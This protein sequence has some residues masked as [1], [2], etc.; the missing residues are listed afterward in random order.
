MTDRLSPILVKELRQGMRARMFESS[1]V[2]VQV[3]VVLSMI[4]ALTAAA[5]Q[6]MDLSRAFGDG[7]FWIVLA[8]SLL[9]IMPLRGATAL[10]SEARLGALDLLFLTRLSAWR[11]VVGKWAALFAQSCLV[12]CAVLPYG[13]LRYYLG[14]VDLVRDSMV[15]L[16][17]MLASALFTALTVS[18]SAFPS[19]L[20]RILVV[21]VPLMVLNLLPVGLMA[22]RAGPMGG[23]GMIG[24]RSDWHEVL[25]T[26]GYALIILAYILQMGAAR[27]APPAENHALPKRLLGLLL[28]PAGP[29]AVLAGADDG[30]L[31]FTFVLLVPV[32]VD[33][34]CANPPPVPGQFRPF[35]RL[36]RGGWWV[37]WLFTPGWVSGVLYTL[38]AM[39]LVLVGFWA[40]GK[41]NPEL[42]LIWVALAG[43][44][45]LPIALALLLKP[46]TLRMGVAY[47]LI[48]LVL[49]VASA[50]FL[51]LNEVLDLDA[52]ALACLCPLTTLI[53]SLA[54]NADTAWIPVSTAI[55]AGILGIIA[56]VGRD[57]FRRHVALYAEARS[58]RDGR[59]RASPGEREAP[60]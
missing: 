53:F 21:V 1:F 5:R 46:K 32:W 45:L 56:F 37:S 57:G 14:S 34:L 4:V 33:A 30:I 49:V 10:R 8:L 44:L 23:L 15:I 27:I 47:A 19:K 39:G 52:D 9:L 35:L 50:L 2:L 3:L 54:N 16:G 31:V 11:I 51:L 12:L 60:S 6:K 28:V 20:A 18:V 29:L 17:L 43:T 7:A 55:L 36:P 25:I 59:P 24:G 22:I 40:R 38:A 42:L 58:A 26:L 41:A 13:V 48:Q